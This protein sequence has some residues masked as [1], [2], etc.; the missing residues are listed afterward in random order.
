M[1]RK[2]PVRRVDNH[3]SLV[4]KQDDR[5]KEETRALRKSDRSVQKGGGRVVEWDS[6]VILQRFTKEREGE[7]IN[8]KFASGRR[9]TATDIEEGTKKKY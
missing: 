4:Q 2:I 8:S 1:L 3:G 6:W 5:V 7:K 9:E